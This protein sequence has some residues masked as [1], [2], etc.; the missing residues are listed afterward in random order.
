M[1]HK[2][3]N[4]TCRICLSVGEE[5]QRMWP[6][7]EACLEQKTPADIIRHCFGVEVSKSNRA[8]DE[9]CSSCKTDLEAAHRFLKQ[10]NESTEKLKIVAPKVESGICLDNVEVF[11]TEVEVKTEHAEEYLEDL[12]EDDDIE[13]QEQASSKR[14]RP[15]RKLE[16]VK[17][18]P[19]GKLQ[20][21]V[22]PKSEQR[23]ASPKFEIL[24]SSEEDNQNDASDY[25]QNITS[26]DEDDYD[27]SDKPSA[28]RTSQ[29]KKSNNQP[30]RCCS[31]KE[32]LD[33]HEKVQKHSDQYHLNSRITNPKE[34]GNRVFECSVCYQRFDTKILYLR[35][36]RK[37]YV[38]KLHPCSR[39]EEEFANLF[40][41]KK[42]IKF[43]HKK[44]FKTAQMEE[45]RSK[46]NLCCGCKKQFPTADALKEH[47]EKVHL[48]ERVL[49]DTPN[50]FECDVCYNRFKTFKSLKH[51]QLRFFKEK[52]FIC[53]LCGKSFREKMRLAEHENLHRK[54]A[55]F[56]CAHCPAKFAIKNS[57]EVHVKMHDAE[58]IYNCEYCGKGFRKKSLL[59]G[60][61]HIHDTDRPFKCHLCPITFTRQ[62][63]LDAHL[64]AHSGSKP[65]KC[66]QC[67]ASYIHQRD[68]RRHI[69][70]KHE[71]IRSFKC[72]LC[73]KAYIRHKLLETHLKT[74]ND[75]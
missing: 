23:I 14:A 17:S 40:V 15:K 21:T 45:M 13:S 29:G 8:N 70:E 52:K 62:N 54:I 56:Q 67:A 36:Q 33:S 63:L 20:V 41:L 12:K 18:P 4:L 43:D 64:L 75:D 16:V 31:C 72:H 7:F 27:E 24:S 65:H 10:L 74:H 34:Y 61:L 19:K 6:L 60:H 11:I 59:M 47:V 38:D 3:E 26:D 28:R 66:Q 32:P 30:K 9:I 73:P 2:L 1:E 53:T 35:H 71:G 55:P 42:H 22:T 50:T 68:L 37:M 25:E 51:H 5:S 49:Y 57:F 69:R 48:K 39:C 44:Q 58:E 46:V